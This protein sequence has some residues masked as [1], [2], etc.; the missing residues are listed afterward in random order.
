MDLY[1]YFKN[2]CETDEDR[3]STIDLFMSWNIYGTDC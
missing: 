2:A 1:I 3:K